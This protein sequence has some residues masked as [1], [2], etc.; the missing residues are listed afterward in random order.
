MVINQKLFEFSDF[1]HTDI[2][3][4]IHTL[5]CS[6][7][8]CYSLHWLLVNTE[9]C[10]KISDTKFTSICTIPKSAVIL[11]FLNISFIVNIYI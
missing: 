1:I 2:S 5:K 10:F 8:L 11:L 9:N 3:S 6:Q 7:S 4:Y